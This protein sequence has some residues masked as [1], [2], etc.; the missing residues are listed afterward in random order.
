[1]A[2]SWTKEQQQV[3]DLSN[4][5]ILVSAAAG[6]GKTAVLVER[7][8]KK[9]TDKTSYNSAYFIEDEELNILE[10]LEYEKKF[11]NRGEKNA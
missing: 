5:D 7:I 8:I 1:M 2:V 10:K 3:I 11:N 4:R 6:S 9:I